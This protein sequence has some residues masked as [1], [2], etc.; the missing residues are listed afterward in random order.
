MIGITEKMEREIPAGSNVRQE[1]GAYQAV[2][3]NCGSSGIA[4]VVGAV[5]EMANSVAKGAGCE[6]GGYWVRSVGFVCCVEI[7]N[8][9]DFVIV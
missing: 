7:A 3:D 4:C 5:M 6:E 9:D 1:F 8:N 2:V